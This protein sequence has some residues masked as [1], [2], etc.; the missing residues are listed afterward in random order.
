MPE[1][2]ADTLSGTTLKATLL[3]TVA[4]QSHWESYEVIRTLDA[5]HLKQLEYQHPFCKRTGHLFPGDSFVENSTGTGFVHIAP[6]HGLDDYLHLKYLC[7]G[8]LD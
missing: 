2:L 1:S 4:E 6:S 8:Q 5:D 3:K 7:Q